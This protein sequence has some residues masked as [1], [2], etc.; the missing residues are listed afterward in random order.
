MRRLIITTIG[1]F[2]LAGCT[3]NPKTPEQIRQDAANAASSASHAADVATRDAQAAVEGVKDGLHA[4]Q[5]VN[6]NTSSRDDLTALPG[7]D[8]ATADKIINGRPY[9]AISDLLDRHLV[10]QTEYNRISGK[11][12]TN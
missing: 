5:P 4:G 11:I 7:M 9:S 12:I 8:G 2:A 1:L 10:S 3:P 6:I